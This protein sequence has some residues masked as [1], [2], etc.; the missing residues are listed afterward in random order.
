MGQIQIQLPKPCQENWHAM[1]IEQKGRFCNA[2]QKTVYDFTKKSDREILAHLN[3]DP[4]T[5]G[6]FLST[7][8]DRNLV[9]PTQKNTI[10]A[11]T[12]A[13]FISL[14]V[15]GSN[16]ASAQTKQESVHTYRAKFNRESAKQKVDKPQPVPSNIPIKI[17]GTV[18]EG[19]LP[20]PTAQV[21]IQGKATQTQTDFD[22]KFTIDAHTG[23]T[24]SVSFI[25]YSDYKI[26]LTQSEENL[27]VNLNSNEVYLGEMMVGA[28]ERTTFFG[29]IFNRV[30]NLFREEE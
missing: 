30:R 16:D 9:A 5:C 21:Q 13:G 12:F 8:L 23:D 29:R 7:Q 19:G 27:V 4:N 11:A 24:L 6:R 20:M 22:G 1:S 3:S 25:G 14:F 2:C 10:W 17:S 18:I 26:V 15:L 28:I